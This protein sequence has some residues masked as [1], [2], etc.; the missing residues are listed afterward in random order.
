MIELPKLP[1]GYDALEPCI[2][3]RTLRLHHGKHHKAYVDKG[4]D[5]ISGT[6]L[7]DADLETIIRKAH[8]DK[9]QGL[10]NQAAQVWNH[11]FYWHSMAPG[12]GGEP[13]GEI[14]ERIKKDFG[15]Y[16]DFRDQLLKT[17]AGQFGS[18]YGWLVLDGGSLKVTSTSNAVPPF[19][20]GQVPVL[21]IDVWEHSYYLDYQNVR[22]DYLKTV[23]DKLL[24]WEFAAANLA[25]P[26]GVVQKI[27]KEA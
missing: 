3:E 18:G 5:L 13:G 7:A 27:S 26:D 21:G 19:V 6:D 24:N 10:F 12:A 2:S 8:A 15:S 22:P 17:A 20:E 4:N 23:V 25:D 9:N 1:Y 14:A 11:T 16:A